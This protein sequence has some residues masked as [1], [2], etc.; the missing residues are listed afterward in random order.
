MNYNF[1]A[2]ID[3]N[4]K[5][6]LPQEWIEN[7][8]TDDGK[9]ALY[10]SGNDLVIRPIRESDEDFFDA[11]HLGLLSIARAKNHLVEGK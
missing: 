5:L 3:S 1:S 10:T 9:V 4:G 11:E 6:T 8:L 7:N 2:E